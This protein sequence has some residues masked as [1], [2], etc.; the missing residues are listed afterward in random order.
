VPFVET[1]ELR[2]HY[3]FDGPSDAPP[4]VFSNSLGTTM[5]LWQP[6]ISAFSQAFR[7]LRY[8]SR[9]HGDTAVT[10]R[11]YSIERLANDVLHLLDA[12]KLQRV[13]F[14]GLSIG[15]MTGMWLGAN[16]PE[17]L[18]KLVL[19]NTAAKLGNTE[20]WNARIQA[21]RSG[22]TPSVAGAVIARWFTPEF[23]EKDPEKV[24]SARQMLERTNAVGYMGSCAAVRDFDFRQKLN[25]IH[26]PT[27]V[28]SGTHDPVATPADGQYLSAGISGAQYSE[29]NAAHISN[30]EDAERFNTEVSTFLLAEAGGAVNG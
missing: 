30:M 29:V 25:S 1:K 4:L 9:G 27:L 26:A 21:V 12:L 11:E 15:G 19:C 16:A 6:Q 14:C 5:A 13:H 23:R 17:R 10:P 22:G 20:S 7:V 8:D 2:M 18:H 3:Q 24:A 28:V